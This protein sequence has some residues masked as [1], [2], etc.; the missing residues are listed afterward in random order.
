MPE[1][2]HHVKPEGYSE[3]R[4]ERIKRAVTRR[5][6]QRARAQGWTEDRKERCVWGT[7]NVVAERIS[8]DRRRAARV[9]QH[10]GAKT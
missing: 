6:E 5:C 10:T 1:N 2:G 8:G 3:A 7:M 9:E 4:W